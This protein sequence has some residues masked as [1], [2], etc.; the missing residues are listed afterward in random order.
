ME[1]LGMATASSPTADGARRA[2]DIVAALKPPSRDRVGVLE[3][4]KPRESAGR[5]LLGWAPGLAGLVVGAT[6]WKRHRVLG[7]L[8]GNAIGQNA[9]SLVKGGEARKDALYSLGIEGA[10]IGGA[11][12]CSSDEHEYLY[13]ALG[14][15]VTFALATIASSFIP[16]SPVRKRYDEWKSKK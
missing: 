12:L 8:V 15:G 6:A 1:R 16:G 7:A 10:A 4:M 14:Y 2:A 9:W 3:K 11:L 13:P 5:Q